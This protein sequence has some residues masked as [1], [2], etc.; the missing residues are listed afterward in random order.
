MSRNDEDTSRNDSIGDVEKLTEPERSISN[1][2]AKN[3]SKTVSQEVKAITDMTTKATKVLS[4]LTAKNSSPTEAQTVDKDWDFCRFLYHKLKDIPEGDVKDEL[5][6]EIQQI[7]QKTKRQITSC[8]QEMFG[9]TSNVT[10]VVYSTS[11]TGQ[12]HDSVSPV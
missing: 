7:V 12:L 5:Q 9:A 1:T 11:Y 2:A 10:N 3:R 4:N 6:L 8:T